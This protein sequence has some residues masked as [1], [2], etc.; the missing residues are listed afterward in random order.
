MHIHQGQGQ[1]ADTRRTAVLFVLTSEVS[2]FSR[3]TSEE[4]FRNHVALLQE[5]SK[6]FFGQAGIADQAG[7]GI[8]VDGVGPGKRQDSRTV[9]DPRDLA[10]DLRR[11]LDLPHVGPSKLLVNHRQILPDG[12]LNVFESH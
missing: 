1:A 11:H 9:G 4:P 2:G 6:L 7:H 3:R 8:G 12:V 5:P 10:H